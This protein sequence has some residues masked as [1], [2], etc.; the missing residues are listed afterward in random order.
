MRAPYALNTNF[1]NAENIFRGAK[2]SIVG[3]RLPIT[4]K[5]RRAVEYEL[6][7]IPPRLWAT[8]CRRELP[9]CVFS[10]FYMLYFFMLTFYFIINTFLETTSIL[11]AS[12]FVSFVLWWIWLS[13]CLDLSRWQPP[14]CT[15]SYRAF[16]MYSFLFYLFVKLQIYF[17]MYLE[18][19]FV[20]Q[21]AYNSIKET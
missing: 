13:R 1:L 19:I 3:M 8:F 15:Y 10:I 7:Q 18:D 20:A 21:V 2:S 16:F 11:W 14:K 5:A 6:K 4:L 12:G 9:L 17:F